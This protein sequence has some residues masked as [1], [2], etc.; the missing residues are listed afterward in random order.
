[1]FGSPVR[2]P[3]NGNPRI[4]WAPRKPTIDA[5]SVDLSEGKNLFEHDHVEDYSTP[6]RPQ[7]YMLNPPRVMRNMENPNGDESQKFITPIRFPNMDDYSDVES[8]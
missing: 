2:P 7:P 4:T 8:E 5:L 1:M 6:F 3:R